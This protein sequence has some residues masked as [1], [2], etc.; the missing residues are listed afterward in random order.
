MERNRRQILFART[1]ECSVHMDCLLVISQG[2]PGTVTGAADVH[3]DR[4]KMWWCHQYLFSDGEMETGVGKAPATSYGAL[5]PGAKN[6]VLVQG[7]LY[8]CT[9]LWG[10]I[11]PFPEKK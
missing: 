6:V 10:L 1:Q 2:S 5:D 7:R 11:T 9:A 3:P 8:P 4:A